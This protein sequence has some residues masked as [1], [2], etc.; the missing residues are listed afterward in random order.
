[1]NSPAPRGALAEAV[2]EIDTD[3]EPPPGGLTLL[4]GIDALRPA[5]PETDA[6]ASVDE[7]KL[8]LALVED[9]WVTLTPPP[10]LGAAS[11]LVA[12]ANV[13]AT[14]VT[15]SKKAITNG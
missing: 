3:Q 1:M 4:P 10:Q 15:N 5:E 11:A 13:I 14:A 12:V 8:A 7:L 6:N 9:P 2:I